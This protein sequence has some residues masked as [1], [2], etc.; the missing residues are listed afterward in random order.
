MLASGATSWGAWDVPVAKLSPPVRPPGTGLLHL[1]TFNGA[2]AFRRWKTTENGG[3]LSFTLH[4]QWGHRLSAMET[5]VPKVPITSPSGVHPSMGPPPFGDGN[6]HHRLDTRLTKDFN[7]ATAFRRWKQGEL[8]VTP[9][10]VP[11][12]QPSMGPPPFGDGNCSRC[13]CQYTRGGSA[14]QWG[15]RLS[16]METP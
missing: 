8:P 15:H 9:A 2:T 1:L 5:R 10:V 12:C 13:A 6:G 16:A 3:W 4:L 11:A 14:L 7:G